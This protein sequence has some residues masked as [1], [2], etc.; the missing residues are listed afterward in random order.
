MSK[1]QWLAS[2]FVE[3]TKQTFRFRKRA[4]GGHE[5]ELRRRVAYLE[6]TVEGQNRRIDALESQISSLRE[7]IDRLYG[8]SDRR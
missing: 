3:R 6:G 1:L 7:R 5:N 4:D 8:R 2:E